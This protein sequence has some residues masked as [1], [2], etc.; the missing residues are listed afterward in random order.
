MSRT[1]PTPGGADQGG[2]AAVR[3]LVGGNA[4]ISD[5]KRNPACSGL[6]EVGQFAEEGTVIVAD[7]DPDGLTAAMK[8]A[9]VFYPEL[10][11]DADVLDGGRVGQ[12]A[13]KLSAN[14]FLFVRAM[15]SLPTFDAARP[16]V[17]EKAK[18][19]LFSNFVAVVQGNAEAKVKLEKGVETYEAGVREAEKLAATVTDIMSGVSYVDLMTSPRFDLTT[20]A[21]KMDARPGT[22]VT[23]QK[24]AVGPIA[25][26]CGGIQYSLAVVK[27]FQAEI[28]LQGLLPTGFTSSPESGIISNTSFLLHVSQGVWE[29]Q[30]LPRV[31]GEVRRLIKRQSLLTHGVVRNQEVT[32]P[33]QLYLS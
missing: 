10:D 24:K 17:S 21:G 7:P 26:K 4:I 33:S 13:D 31:D 23:V 8:T 16:D 15:A 12:T 27:A 18:A 6:I 2:G 9:G 11:S 28:N 3:D 30:V 19:E 14:A 25:A 22:K 5:R 32:N 20:L 29:S 1:R